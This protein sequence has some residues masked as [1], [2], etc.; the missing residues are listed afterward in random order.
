M[1]YIPFENVKVEAESFFFFFKFYP[2]L[3]AGRPF[4]LKKK[5]T[6]FKWNIGWFNIYN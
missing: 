3:K 5:N 6:E 1:C 4:N 2:T